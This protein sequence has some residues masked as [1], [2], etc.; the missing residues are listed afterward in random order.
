MTTTD[1][2]AEQLHDNGYEPVQTSSTHN[3][4]GVRTRTWAA[5]GFHPLLNPDGSRRD[6]ARALNLVGV[7][8]EPMCT[9]GGDPFSRHAR[10][11]ADALVEALASSGALVR[12]TAAS[13]LVIYRT[14]GVEAALVDPTVQRRPL[15]YP[16]GVAAKDSSA[17][18]RLAASFRDVPVADG[19]DW[20]GG[21]SP[22]TVARDALPTWSRDVVSRAVAEL[23]DAWVA[24]G[25]LRVCGGYQEPA[26]PEGYWSNEA[27]LARDGV[28]I[29][30]AVDEWTGKSPGDLG[31]ERG[32]WG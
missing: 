6:Y 32:R 25:R 7:V 17:P 13:L 10:K 22:L 23:A 29:G 4:D 15:L 16:H 3:S 21:R 12:R 31:R 24:Q 5:V 1:P 26:R 28:T 9:R 30:G 19:A 14:D 18:L 2:I 8:L 20:V 27:A 11:F